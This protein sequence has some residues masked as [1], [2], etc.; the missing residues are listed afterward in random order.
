[1]NFAEFLRTPFVTEHLWTTAF[2]PN[3]MKLQILISNSNLLISEKHL[4]V[5]F[6]ATSFLVRK[7]FHG[8]SGRIALGLLSVDRIDL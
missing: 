6:Y 7:A 8:L 5:L 2:E 4:S 3:S 1:M